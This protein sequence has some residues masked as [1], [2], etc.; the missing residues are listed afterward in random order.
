VAGAGLLVLAVGLQRRLDAAYH[1]TVALL[2]AGIMLSLL[3]GLDYVEAAALAVML[4]ALLPAHREFYRKTSLTAEPFTPGWTAAVLLV[5]VSSVWLGFFAYRHVAYSNE[6]WWRFALLADAP[7]FL[8]ATVGAL[9]V[10][11]LFAAIRLLRPATA[12]VAPPSSEE[13]ERAASVAARSPRTYANLSLLGDKS[14]LFNDSGTAFVMFRVER[15]SWVSMGDP[16]GPADEAEEL[17][18]RFYEMAD[19][20]GDRAVFYQVT[21]EYLHLYLELGFGLLKLGEEA[22]VHLP[23]FSLEGGARR[24]LRH[25]LH[26]AE[27]EGCR[28]EMVTPAEVERL[29]PELRRISGAWLEEKGTREKGFS[30][31]FFDERYLARFPAALIR[32]GDEILAFANVWTA[33]DREEVSPDLMRHRPEAP[34]GVMEYL[35]TELMLWG[36]AEGY[37]WFNLGMAPLSG[38]QSRP[39]A[40]IWNRLGALIYRYAD[41]FYNFQGLRDFKDKFD[42]VWTP[43]YLASEGGFALPAVLAN[44]S[45]LIA[46][47]VR[48]IFSR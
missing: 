19:Q 38:L 4:A 9:A 34:S 18:W 17:V 45:T 8:R 10:T 23:E 44:V 29:L 22:R 42:P 48:G 40:P 27:R 6:L 15:G 20:H 26:R 28:F 43:K 46:G 30:M 31:G 1:L 21:P 33:A 5:L 13:L 12:E 24:G 25:A 36:R 3:R 37:R 39:L 11:L 47:G 14:L 7:R 41:Y 16:V 32:R 2:A 35:F